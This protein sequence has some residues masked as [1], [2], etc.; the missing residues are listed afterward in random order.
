MLNCSAALQARQCQELQYFLH[1][2]CA[3]RVSGTAVGFLWDPYMQRTLLPTAPKQDT[4]LG[5]Q[6]IFR[7]TWK[8]V[9]SIP[10]LCP[11]DRDHQSPELLLRQFTA[12]L[13]SHF[14][15]RV[16]HNM[17]VSILA[18]SKGISFTA[19]SL[20]APLTPTLSPSLSASRGVPPPSLGCSRRRQS[21]MVPPVEAMR[22]R[23]RHERCR[24]YPA[25][26][27]SRVLPGVIFCNISVSL[28]CAKH[29]ESV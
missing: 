27:I 5:L 19:I 23:P 1:R 7:L 11:R 24:Q 9:C 2:P 18:C 15:K 4:W 21:Q 25:V 3:R 29:L 13:N 8:K 14:K 22:C 6:H 17:E 28:L 16:S 12:A 10:S 20:T 26:L